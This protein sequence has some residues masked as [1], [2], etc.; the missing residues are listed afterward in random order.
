MRSPPLQPTLC[1][2]RGKMEYFITF[3]ASALVW[4]ALL[5]PYLGAFVPGRL[6]QTQ[7]DSGRLR[8][9]QADT[10]RFKQTRADL[11]RLRQT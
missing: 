1:V 7:A 3:P 4:K 5:G 9:T 8:Q 2:K 10:G 11:G 6:R